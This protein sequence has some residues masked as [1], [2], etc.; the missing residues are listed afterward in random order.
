MN[1]QRAL[2]TGATGFVGSNLTRLLLE[3]GCDV[4]VLVRKGSDRRNLPA[5][6]G[7]SLQVFEGDLRDADSVRKAVQDC[8]E[9]YHVAADYRF[10]SRDPAELYASNV[11]GTRNLLEA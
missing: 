7:A 9:I 5:S 11:E 3:K 4:R 10:W 8:S 1:T 6:A 2:V